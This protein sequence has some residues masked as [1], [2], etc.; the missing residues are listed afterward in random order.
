LLSNRGI[1]A[2]LGEISG[3]MSK[4]LWITIVEQDEEA[5]QEP[6]EAISAK[7]SR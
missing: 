1:G 5:K 4:W 2:V 7:Q 6:S 3:E